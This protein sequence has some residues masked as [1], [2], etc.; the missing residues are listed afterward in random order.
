MFYLLISPALHAKCCLQRLAAREVPVPARAPP[1]DAHAPELPAW[2]RAWVTP[3]PRDGGV[4]LPSR[5]I[6]AVACD[7]HHSSWWNSGVLRTILGVSR[8]Y[9]L[10]AALTDWHQP[11]Q[12]SHMLKCFPSLTPPLLAPVLLRHH[13]LLFRCIQQ[14]PGLF[15][16]LL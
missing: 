11:F 7:C 15:L 12:V 5:R 10:C 9:S 16:F 8:M 14:L 6:I 4:V 1:G 13:L 3:Y 2:H